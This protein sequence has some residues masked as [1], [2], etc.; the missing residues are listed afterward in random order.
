MISKYNGKLSLIIEDEKLKDSRK[1][2]L[3]NELYKERLAQAE[4]IAG[5]SFG[6]ELQKMFEKYLK[7]HITVSETFKD[8]S[9]LTDYVTRDSDVV[10]GDIESTMLTQQIAAARTRVDAL[11]AHLKRLGEQMQ[12][13]DGEDKR[14]Q[15]KLAA[16][17][18]DLITREKEFKAA[19]KSRPSKQP[20]RK[21][22]K[23]I[24]NLVA[25]AQKL[26][27]EHAELM[28]NLHAQEGEAIKGIEEEMQRKLQDVEE[29]LKNQFTE[30]ELND[31]ET[32]RTSTRSEGAAQAS[33][34][35]D[36]QG[37]GRH[38]EGPEH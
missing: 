15:D 28:K 14:T 19:N 33:R 24:G 10:V 20:T 29:R 23:K 36:A 31:R 18:K 6:G 35:S 22:E 8:E 11:K 5:V 1:R 13:L 25:E 26:R 2:D 32:H 38:R 9:I 7:Q 30:D 21:A 4:M 34:G 37:D 3:E 16:A 12:A 17:K 27:E